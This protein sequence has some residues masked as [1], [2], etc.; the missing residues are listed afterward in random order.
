MDIEDTNYV[1][2]TFYNNSIIAT[3][4][5]LLF[6]ISSLLSNK[7]KSEGQTLYGF[8]IVSILLTI[9]ETVFV[10]WYNI[11]NVYNL[12]IQ[13]ILSKTNGNSQLLKKI[14]KMFPQTLRT[15]LKNKYEDNMKNVSFIMIVPL[16]LLSIFLLSLV[17][18]LSWSK[19]PKIN[20]FV[21]FLNVSLLLVTFGATFVNLGIKSSNKPN[22]NEVVKNFNFYKFNSKFKTKLQI[23]NIKFIF[24]I[25]FLCITM[26][27]IPSLFIFN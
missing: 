26:L 14:N 11:Q 21:I 2:P 1:H 7:T 5:L 19:F 8:F 12:V 10:Y 16:I 20:F 9:I 15:I 24:T 17:N 3:I 23:F 13:T 4:I 22:F 27:L 18:S 25:I 6:I